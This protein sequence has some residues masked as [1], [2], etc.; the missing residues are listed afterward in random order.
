VPVNERARAETLI[1]D[2]RSAL[3]DEN[4]KLDRLRQLTSDLQQVS[5]A[6]ASAAYGQAS[7]AGASA[8]GGGGGSRT[9][10][11]GGDDVIDAEYTPK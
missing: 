6:L 5:H 4:T 7:A 1:N 10:T 9:S 3:K 2:I 11:D 8:S